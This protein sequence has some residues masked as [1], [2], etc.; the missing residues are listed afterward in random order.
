MTGF[1]QPLYIVVN[2]LLP[3]LE[4]NP[5]GYSVL[6][7]NFSWKIKPEQEVSLLVN[8]LTNDEYLIVPGY[9]AEQRRFTLQ[10]KIVF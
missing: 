6:D 4:R 1:D 2:D 3:F 9:L 10:Y 5:K 8:N 7:L